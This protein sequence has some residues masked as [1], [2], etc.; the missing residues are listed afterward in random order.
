M[1]ALVLAEFLKFRTTRTSIGV[2]VA[3]AAL[4]GIATAGTV[5]TARDDQL[6]TTDLS[7][8]IVS[9]ALV[10]TLI[11][12]LLGVMAVTMEW[13]HGTVTRT[14]LITPRRGLVLVAKEAWLAGL[15]VV[16]SVLALAL[17]LAIA[18]PWLSIEGS[19]FEVDGGVV[20]LAGRAVLASVLWGALG[21][22][23]GAV[24][25]NQT[26][27]LIGAVIWILP[28]EGLAIALLGVF[29]LEDL[30]DY[31]PGQALSGVDGT[32]DGG[33]SLWPAIA[34]A[35]AYIAAFAAVGWFR[36]RRQDIT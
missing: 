3:A 17:A 34:V 8:D 6:G 20:G 12:F 22:G 25:Q 18:L 28:V 9:S 15:A 11:V 26:A 27:A 21:V 7:R 30:G 36:I 31:L 16:L 2:L 10:T 24:I 13:R 32:S 4:T 35:I 5:G 1:S 19:S 14:F 29:E 33:L 23:V